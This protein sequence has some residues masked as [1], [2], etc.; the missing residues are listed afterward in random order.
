MNKYQAMQ[1]F[2]ESFGLPAYERT[3]VPIKDPL[4]EFPYLTYD[5][6]A[7]FGDQE[8]SLSFDIWYRDTSL[9]AISRKTQE[10]VQA[11]GYAKRIWCDEGMILI[12]FNDVQPMGDDSDPLIERKVFSLNAKFITTY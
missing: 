7:S 3:K 12:R 11:I 5:S 2:Y 9:E 1:D 10:I 6:N 4:P 8:I